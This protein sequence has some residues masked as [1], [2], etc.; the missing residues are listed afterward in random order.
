MSVCGNIN[1]AGSERRCCIQTWVWMV[2]CE[3]RGDGKWHIGGRDQQMHTSITEKLAA[4]KSTLN[5]ERA[6]QEDDDDELLPP[7]EW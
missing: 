7:E 1:S 5:W 6:Y 2:R 3:Q 4:E